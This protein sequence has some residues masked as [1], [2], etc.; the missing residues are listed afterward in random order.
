MQSSSAA[1]VVEGYFDVLAAH[2]AGVSNAVASSGTALTREQVR[3]LSRHAHTLI[4][5][6]DGDD[7]G[8]VAAS[9]AVDV[10]AAENLDCRICVLPAGFKDPDELVRRD[11]A[12]FAEVVRTAPREWQVL[13]DA[14]IGDGEGG[15]IDARR[16]AAE[17]AVAL[18]AR[19]PEAAARDL[20]VQQAADRLG[21]QRSSVAQDVERARR[22]GRPARVVVTAPAAPAQAPASAHPEVFPEEE[23]IPPADPAEDRLGSY[24]LQRPALAAQLLG[25]HGLRAEELRHPHV[26]RFVEVAL[27]LPPGASFPLHQ[28]SASEQRLAARLLVRSLPELQELDDPEP[29]RRALADCVNRIREAGREAEILSIKRELRRARDAG[30]S[31]EEEALALRLYQLA[32]E[33]Q[34]GRQAG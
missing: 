22:S 3:I 32:T 19:I 1:V 20:Y 13:L 23:E 4:L 2:Q 31:A 28:L 11:P 6:F 24:V 25:E 8:R 12:L 7:A 16:D 30:Q 34:Q 17:R 14:A 5:C 21:L 18:L 10:V 33:R 26:R 27:G 15:S 29:L 9:R